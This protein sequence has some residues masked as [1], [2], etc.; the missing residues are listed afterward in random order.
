MPMSGLGYCGLGRGLSGLHWVWF[1][2]RGPHLELRRE[3]QCSSLFLTSI[4][5]S[6]QSWNKRVR[7]RLVLRHV[8]PLASQHVHGVTGHLSNYIWNL[9]VLPDDVTGV[10]MPLHVVTSST[11]L[12]SKRCLCIGFLSRADREIRVFQNV[13]LP[14]MLHLVFLREIGLILR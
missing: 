12:H 11:G 13:A 1:N 14:T 10:S 8:T 6:L 5:V 3:T 4:A 9:R 7:P 2:G